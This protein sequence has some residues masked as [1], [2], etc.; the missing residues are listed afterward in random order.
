MLHALLH[1]ERLIGM[2][3]DHEICQ[4]MADGLVANKFVQKNQLH[5]HSYYE[6]SITTGAYD[7]DDNIEE[8]S[9][10]EITDSNDNKPINTENKPINKPIDKP[11]DTNTAD[12][13]TER[14]E[15][16]QSLA[17][18][19]KEKERIDNSINVYTVDIK[20]Y[21]QF[22]KI[23]QENPHFMVP[24]MFADKYELMFGLDQQN[25]LCWENFDELYTP[26]VVATGYSRIFDGHPIIPS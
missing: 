26:K 24:E 19:K 18:L 1:N 20:L 2:F 8:F 6:N 3:S 14:A 25:K 5:I 23:K 16:M 15:L 21:N 4:R 7:A 9:N 11:N 22:K 17:L 10:N 13:N 12:N